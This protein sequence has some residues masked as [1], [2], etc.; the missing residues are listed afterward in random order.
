MGGRPGRGCIYKC[1]LGEGECSA[2]PPHSAPAHLLEFAL[3]VTTAILKGD[4]QWTR[5]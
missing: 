4:R 5:S 3:L 2:V 1:V